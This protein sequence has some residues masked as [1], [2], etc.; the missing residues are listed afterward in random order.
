MCCVERRWEDPTI[1]GAD[2]VVVGYIY[3]VAGEANTAGGRTM[4]K[5]SIT[6]QRP[7]KYWRDEEIFCHQPLMYIVL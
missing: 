6:G 5:V 3:L 1:S 7:L 4:G 2:A